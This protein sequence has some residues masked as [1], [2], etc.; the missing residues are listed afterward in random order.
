MA[1]KAT[2]TATI[3]GGTLTSNQS[4][5]RNYETGTIVVTGGTLTGSY[6]VNNTGSGN[7]II[8][9]GSINSKKRVDMDYGY[10][11]SNK[12]GGTVTVTG[13]TITGVTHGIY[14]YTGGTVTIGKNDS[15]IKTNTPIIQTNNTADAPGYGLFN[16]SDAT[17]NFYDG[18]IKS[19]AGTGYS[20]RRE[21]N[22]VPTDYY[23]YKETVSGVE[24]AILV[25]KYYNINSGKSFS[26]LSAA[27][28]AVAS[29]QTIKVMTNTTETTNATLISNK[30]GIKLDLNGKTITMSNSY[31]SNAGGLDIYNTS[32][33]AGSIKG[34]ANYVLYNTGSLSLNN[35]SSTNK[36]LI[37]KTSSNSTTA[38]SVTCVISNAT[39]SATFSMKDN[40]E[41]TASGGTSHGIDNDGMAKILAGKVTGTNMGV[42]NGPTG[43]L[44]LGLN[45]GNVS[46]TSP[47]ILGIGSYGL[48]NAAGDTYF[49]DG[50]V[51][52]QAGSSYAYHHTDGFGSIFTPTSYVLKRSISSNVE[53]AYLVR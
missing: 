45:D 13:G 53:S 29:S 11:I 37:E 40:V 52:S 10:G 28:S 9:G 31:I 24:S 17:F 26:T 47:S 21:P 42:E 6:G 3:A 19:P 2:G 34:G 41:V 7:V 48:N 15:E 30:S 51:K 33:T 12:G 43:K 36:V 8:S 23:V 16:L 44:Y 35:T 18:V 4:C 25:G 14:N 1:N 20:L 49:Y 39:S 32:S 22:S 5:T 50:V 38:G 27:L 46:T